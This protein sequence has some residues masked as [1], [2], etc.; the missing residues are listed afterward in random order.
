M[1]G[2]RLVNSQK[3][4]CTRRLR[5]AGTLFASALIISAN[6][7]S[8][9]YTENATMKTPSTRNNHRSGSTLS[10]WASLDVFAGSPG[11]TSPVS[12]KGTQYLSTKSG[13]K[14]SL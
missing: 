1:A 5:Y 2:G 10:S 14:K 6:P 3:L 9:E 4:E 12:R 8:A 7:A 13:V 11:K